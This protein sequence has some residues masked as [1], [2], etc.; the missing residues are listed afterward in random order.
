M[1]Q[2]H[3]DAL[4]DARQDTVI[5]DI[6]IV[7]AAIV[8][9]GADGPLVLCG[10]RSAPERVA[11]RWE[12]PGGKV[13]AGESDQDAVVRECR[14]ELGIVV[15]AG[16]Q[17]GAEERIDE[18][19]VLRVY[20]AAAAAGEPEPLPLEDHDL[21]EWIAPGRLAELDWLPADVPIVAELARLLTDVETPAA[22]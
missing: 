8:R 18:R 22:R 19:M 14:E 12:F 7:G 10:R 15:V 9:R 2:A 17:I 13:E 21:L 11:G 5:G 4:P 20:L 16:A 3:H 1:D 6:V